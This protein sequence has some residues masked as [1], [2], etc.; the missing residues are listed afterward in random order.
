MDGPAGQLLGACKESLM[1]LLL[2]HLGVL[3][4][5]EEFFLDAERKV[6]FKPFARFAIQKALF[7]AGHAPDVTGVAPA[8]VPPT[9]RESL[10]RMACRS[11][12]AEKSHKRRA[13]GLG[14]AFVNY[15]GRLPGLGGRAL[16]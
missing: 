7:H 6:H 13:T 10:D 15:F 5:D 4:Y 11:N 14:G 16:M 8:V 2:E 9:T 12:P 3:A 1:G